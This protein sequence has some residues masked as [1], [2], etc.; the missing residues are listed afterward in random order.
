MHEG[1]TLNHLY[2]YLWIKAKTNLS[3]QW[4]SHEK[5]E[6]LWTTHAYK[7]QT[8]MSSPSKTQGTTRWS[9]KSWQTKV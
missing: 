1:K 3:S 2:D 8:P 4:F 6:K 9:K 7:I 5:R